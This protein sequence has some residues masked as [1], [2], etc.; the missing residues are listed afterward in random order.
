MNKHVAAGKLQE[1]S[2]AERLQLMEDIWASLCAAPDKL[3]VPDWHRS[4]LDGRM[5][6]HG[7]DPAAARP[8]AEVQ[9]EILDALRK[10]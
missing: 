8:W 1:L 2:V 4:E 6:A 5:A 7:R 10:A 3:D 9:A